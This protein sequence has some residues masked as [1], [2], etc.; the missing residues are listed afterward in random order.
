MKQYVRN[1]EIVAPIPPGPYSFTGN[2]VGNKRVVKYA[3]GG[4]AAHALPRS[5]LDIG[6]GVGDLGRIVKTDADTAHWAVDGIDGFRDTC[7]NTALFEKNYYRSVWH[8]LAQDL[9]EDHLKQY[10]AICLFDVIEHLDV[11]GATALLRNLL[12]SLG[13]DSRLVMSTPLWFWPQAHQNP[14]DLEEHLIAVPA[15]SLLSMAPLMFSV[16]SR[17]LVGTFVF[18]R[19]SLALMHNFRPT[20]D[21]SFGLDA[22]RA[23]LL[24]C[25]QE[26]DDILKIVTPH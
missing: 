8:G 15:S 11:E 14:D 25:G 1:Y 7:C 9:P 19:Q 17:F 26:A 22:G 3:F 23:D 12:D 13:P 10:D 2:S 5:V 20:N 16:D 18:G 6:F 21:R 24:S 4:A